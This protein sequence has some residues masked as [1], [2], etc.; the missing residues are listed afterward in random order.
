MASLN[1]GIANPLGEVQAPPSQPPSFPVSFPSLL[2]LQ[3]CLAKVCGAALAEGK[4]RRG[5]TEARRRGVVCSPD[6][7]GNGQMT[8]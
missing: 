2:I 8:N 3:T 4:G 6:G 7:E 1:S 5:G